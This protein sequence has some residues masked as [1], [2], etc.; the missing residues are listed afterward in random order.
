MTRTSHMCRLTLL[1]ILSCLVLAV[2]LSLEVHPL[3]V[4]KREQNLEFP[5]HRATK[6][7]RMRY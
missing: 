7:H 4:I 6:D 1:F 3:E 2:S 5:N